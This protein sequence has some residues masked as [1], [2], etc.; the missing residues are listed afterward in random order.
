MANINVIMSTI[1][2][3]IMKFKKIVI[4]TLKNNHADDL[5]K[6]RHMKIHCQINQNI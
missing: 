2:K 6:H 5:I 3:T 4:K 1:V